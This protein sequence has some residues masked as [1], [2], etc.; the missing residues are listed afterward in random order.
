MSRTGL[1]ATTLA[2]GLRMKAGDGSAEWVY[3]PMQVSVLLDIADMLDE[4]ESAQGERDYWKH[5]AL[6]RI[7]TSG[8]L[9]RVR[10]AMRKERSENA[11]L[12]KLASELYQQVLQDDAAWHDVRAWEDGLPSDCLHPIRSYDDSLGKHA[13]APKFEQRMRELG[14]EVEG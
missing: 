12:R 5:Q 7:C 6:Q 8:E 10:A 1:D 4:I 3:E 9:R 13:V 14:V 11:K 2:N